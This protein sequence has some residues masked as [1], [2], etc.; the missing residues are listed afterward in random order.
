MSWTE[1]RSAPRSSKC[2]AKLCRSICGVSATRIPEILLD[3]G[4]RF[5]TNRNNA[6][7]V[8]FADT[9]NAADLGIE[10]GDAQANELR[11]TQASGIQN[12]KHGAVPEA[13]GIFHI[14]R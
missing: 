9:T 10:V 11:Y 1:R 7:L 5:F 4:Q 13:D 12:L 14:G 6:L 2:V 3:D 8:A